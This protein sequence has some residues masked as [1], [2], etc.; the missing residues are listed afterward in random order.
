MMMALSPW[1]LAWQPDGEL[2]M[3]DKF[4]LL[5]T[6]VVS[7]SVEVQTSLIAAIENL[8]TSEISFS[9]MSSSTASW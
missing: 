5:Q 4:D 2:G 8:S 9:S 3:Q 1:S 7:E 6:L